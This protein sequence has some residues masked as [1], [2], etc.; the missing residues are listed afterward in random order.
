MLKGRLKR[1]EG[2]QCWTGTI[3]IVCG[4]Q[5]GDGTHRWASSHC[6]HSAGEQGGGRELIMRVVKQVSKGRLWLAAWRGTGLPSFEYLTLKRWR[7]MRV[8]RGLVDRLLYL[9][10]HWVQE[11]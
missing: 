7:A 2:V 5:V 3:I 10:G 8:W 6:L 11:S 1:G 4:C 9:A